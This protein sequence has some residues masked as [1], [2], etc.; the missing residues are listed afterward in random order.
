MMKEEEEGGG[1]MVAAI[2]YPNVYVTSH[3]LKSVATN[4]WPE[5]SPS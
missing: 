1:R 2:V 4:F 5:F 3:W